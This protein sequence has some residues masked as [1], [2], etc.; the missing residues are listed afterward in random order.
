MVWLYPLLRECDDAQI[1]LG[2]VKAR[3]TVVSVFDEPRDCGDGCLYLDIAR[4]CEGI[5][6]LN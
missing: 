2:P 3:S 6:C 4:G 1:E 5:I